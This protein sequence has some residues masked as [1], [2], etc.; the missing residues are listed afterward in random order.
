MAMD[1]KLAKEFVKSITS[2]IYFSQ[3]REGSNCLF[4]DDLSIYY[5]QY[6]PFEVSYIFVKD[7]GN[8]YIKDIPFWQRRKLQNYC[9]YARLY[10]YLMQKERD[11]EEY[12]KRLRTLIEKR[13]I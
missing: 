2:I 5:S 10:F 4:T 8:V 11:D 9:Y 6:R 13:K 12:N 3:Y 7:A 1:K